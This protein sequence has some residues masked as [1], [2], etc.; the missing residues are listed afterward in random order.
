MRVADTDILIDIL[1]GFVPA[2]EWFQT[3][4]AE[5][6]S[7]ALELLYQYHLQYR[8]GIMDALIAACVRTRG[9]TLCTF[10]TRHYAAIP[11]LKLESP[12]SK[13]GSNG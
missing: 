4:P 2:I 6:T 13:S 12:Y 7:L 10:N 3:L 9:A 1:R 11:D 5:E 8:I